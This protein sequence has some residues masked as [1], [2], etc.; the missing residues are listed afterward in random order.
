[1]SIKETTKK[2]YETNL[3]KLSLTKRQMLN[4]DTLHSKITAISSND[5]TQRNYYSSVLWW[6]RNNIQDYDDTPIKNII[7]QYKAKVEKQRDTNKLTIK[8]KPK[9]LQWQ[10]IINLRDRLGQQLRENDYSNKGMYKFYCI[11]CVQTY[12][13]PRRLQDLVLAVY[14]RKPSRVNNPKTNYLIINPTRTYV[15]YNHYKTAKFKGSQRF[16]YP[17]ELRNIVSEYIKRND[18]FDGA[19]LFGKTEH[20]IGKFLTAS[21]EKHTGKEVTQNIL[22]HSFISNFEATK[23]TLRKRKKISGQMG[24]S[25]LLQL[26]YARKED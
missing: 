16:F 14:H 21:F 10:Q 22:R 13:P 19:S 18:I 4:L 1:M 25:V 26:E 9:Y 5:S 17:D 15:V 12:L 3:K 24:H 2:A 20:A 6:C 11:L 8:E 7:A 23:P